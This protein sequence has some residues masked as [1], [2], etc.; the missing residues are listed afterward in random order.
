M[1]SFLTL[2]EERDKKF[3][4][5]NAS[6]AALL[7]NKYLELKHNINSLESSKAEYQAKFASIQ[8]N[9]LGSTSTSNISDLNSQLVDL[10]RE[11]DKLQTKNSE[12]EESIQ[13]LQKEKLDAIN[14]SQTLSQNQQKLD[15]ELLEL[16]QKRTTFEQ[17]IDRLTNELAQINEQKQ[18][19]YIETNRLKETLEI[20]EVKIAESA[21]YIKE[22][23]KSN[24]H[25]PM[26]KFLTKIKVHSSAI[27]SICFGPSYE[28]IY[29]VGD[30]KKLIQVSLP[31]LTEI[32]NISTKSTCNQIRYHYESNLACLSCQDKTIR[33]LDA[34]TGRFISELTNHT[35]QCT[36]SCWI[37][38][39]QLLS[40]SLDRTVKLFDL[41]K[42]AVSSTIS[43]ISAVHSICSTN[44]PSV[45]AI[46]TMDGSI[47]LIDTRMK[48]VAQKIDK[49]HARTVC[50]ICSSFNG[51]NIYSIGLDGS[52]CETSIKTMSRIKQ[53]TD[54]NLEL[55]SGTPAKMAINVDGGFLCVPSAKGC[56]CVFDL[57]SPGPPIIN[58]C[59]NVPTTCCAFAANMLVTGDKN[60]TLTFWV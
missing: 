44:E 32:L 5:L 60:H 24:P 23:E 33:V 52:L 14:D 27:T 56:V 57:L 55:K 47:R 48:K 53:I 11:K 40:A 2:L 18:K 39:N 36:D 59:E 3:S 20:Y 25:I 6:D 54:P 49:V 45:F 28:S 51:E 26:K 1:E 8:A 16:G 35:D 31:R 41:T 37:S 22:A 10:Y 13:K 43:A 17:K 19:M 29:T 42:N 30:D 21:N 34:S 50:S 9:G 58:K 12:L 15:D 7:T 46:G 38:R 4:V